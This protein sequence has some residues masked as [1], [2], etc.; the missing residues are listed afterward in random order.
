MDNAIRAEPWLTLAQRGSLSA[1]HAEG[2]RWEKGE[3]KR[4]EEE[5]LQIASRP[6]CAAFPEIRSDTSRRGQQDAPP[7]MLV[8]SHTS[9]MMLGKHTRVCKSRLLL[10]SEPQYVKYMKY[11]FLKI[12]IIVC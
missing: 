11:C 10:L 8:Q 9:E 3:R 6:V 5:E 7:Q 12:F 4:R 2:Q 1:W